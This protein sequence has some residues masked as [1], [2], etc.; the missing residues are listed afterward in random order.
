MLIKYEI[1][2]DTLEKI[3]LSRNV[4]KEDARS[5]AE[6]F[7]NNSLDGV[8]SHGANRFPRLI[9]Y[10]DKGEVNPTTKP[11]IELEIGSLCKMNGNLGIGPL[12]AKIA[13]DKACDLAKVHGIGLVML[14]NTN[15]WMRGGTYG[16]EAANKSMIGICFS[17]TTANMPVW[18]GM[19]PKLGNNPL[20]ISVPRYNGKHVVCDMAI[21]QYS[22]GKVEQTRLLGK[23]LPYPGGFDSN[24]NLTCD[25]TELEK[26]KR[27]LP[28]GYWKG[29]G[30]SLVLDLIATILTGGNSVADITKLGDEV[31]LSQIFIAIDPSKV[32]SS[33][34][35]NNFVEK[36]IADI[37]SSIPVKENGEVYYPGEL[38]A[39]TREENLEKGIPVV[40]EVWAKIQSLIK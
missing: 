19:D 6:I 2:K 12:N 28:I 30:L 26:T 10:M 16:L 3:L 37:K 25:P 34:K 1:L 7:A 35:T 15:H 24:G 32:N 13:M 14:G 5:L 23:Q 36:I 18:G 29:S 20:V 11:K 39:K 17:N 8:Y 27:F 38:S 40:D 9:E 31:G 21:S 33:D 22:Y 4:L